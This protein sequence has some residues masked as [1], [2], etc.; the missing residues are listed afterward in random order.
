METNTEHK[1][2]VLTQQSGIVVTSIA[3]LALAA[4]KIYKTVKEGHVDT[5][6]G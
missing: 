2:L 6:Q 1:S 3:T 5:P 4:I